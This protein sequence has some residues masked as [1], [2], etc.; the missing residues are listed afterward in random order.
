MATLFASSLTF[1]AYR[2]PAADFD[3][4]KR[5]SK[6][7]RKTVAEMKTPENTIDKPIFL[8]LGP[9]SA[10]K[11]AFLSS[12]ASVSKKQIASPTLT[13]GGATSQ[14][15]TVYRRYKP[16]SG[17]L[18]NFILSDVM[19]ISSAEDTEILIDDIKLLVNGHIDEGYE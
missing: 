2:K 17:D 10:G 11:S 3:W 13:S 5:Y 14:I 6:K 16:V 12:V 9:A 1:K 7:L 4:T 19:G 15:T 18:Q 8:V